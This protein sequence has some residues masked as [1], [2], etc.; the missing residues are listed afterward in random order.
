MT[1]D[2]ASTASD[3]GLALRR[4]VY[5]L[6][7]VL[8]AGIT[9]GRILNTQ[10]VLEPSL[11]GPADNPGKLRKWPKDPPTAMPT[12][13]SNDRSR[14]ATIRALVDGPG[15]ESVSRY[16]IGQ[17]VIQSGG[18]YK[19]SG[20]VFDELSAWGTIDRVLHPDRQEFYSSKPPLLP[21]I[22]AGEYWL[23]Q[24]LFGWTL[25]DQPWEVVRTILFTVN[26]LPL[27]V[28]LWLMSRL[29]ERLGTTDWGR[30]F[31]MACACFGT[32]L[33]TFITTLNNHTVA[34]FGVV[35]ALYPCFGMWLDGKREWWRL[36]I[37][38]FFAAWTACNELPATAFAV[39]LFAILCYLQPRQTLLA[40]LPAALLPVAAFFLTNYL[41][42]GT[43]WPAYEKLDTIWYRYEGSHW[44]N[45]LRQPRGID[46]AAD[47]LWVYALHLTFG[48]HGIFSLSPIYMLSAASFLR[49]AREREERAR[50]S[51]GLCLFGFLLSAIVFLF[52]LWK[53]N[54]YGGWTSGPRWFFWLIPLWLLAMIPMLDWLASRRWGRWLGYVLLAFSALS[55]AYPAWNPWRHP[56]IYNLLDHLGRIDY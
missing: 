6:L 15:Q 34:A 36:S 9:A 50:V 52:Y 48:H 56:W 1:N 23:L 26:W 13:S 43:L 31:V 33:T 4:S 42:I 30:M 53:T 44:L 27:L 3:P 40:F 8:T 51:N 11:Y 22:L 39:T 18:R 32:F 16:A 47:P 55:A 28:Y 29:V 49:P 20:I 45:I 24:K 46:A 21:T 19:D 10:L 35:F 17:R 54:N 5:G 25:V 12:F 7:I 37:V 14:W 41:A 2:Q 38:G